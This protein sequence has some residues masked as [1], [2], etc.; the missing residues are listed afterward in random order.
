MSG[1]WVMTVGISLRLKSESVHSLSM[2]RMVPRWF[3]DFVHG[4]VTGPNLERRP[5][6][7][8]NIAEVFQAVL[9]LDCR[10]VRAFR[11]H[12]LAASLCCEV[13]AGLAG[14]HCWRA[15]ECV[16]I[17]SL[18]HSMLSASTKEHKIRLLVAS[19][20][21]LYLCLRPSHI[22]QV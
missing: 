21:D 12:T 3:A 8:H 14:L 20:A 9:H 10:E 4:Q 15:N 6:N 13:R 5:V 7:G 19:I 11:F 22:K 2:G 1:P 16:S 17:P 18:D